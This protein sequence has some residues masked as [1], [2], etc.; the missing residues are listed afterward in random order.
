MLKIV[1][2]LADRDIP[3]ETN[4]PID[5]IIEQIYLLYPQNI[6]FDVIN[7]EIVKKLVKNR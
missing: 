6:G 7:V 2:H 1:V 3:F 5:V 4:E